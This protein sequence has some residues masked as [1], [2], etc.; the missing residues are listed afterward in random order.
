MPFLLVR[1]SEAIFLYFSMVALCFN[2]WM[3]IFT[4]GFPFCSFDLKL[5]NVSSSSSTG[6]IQW[7]TLNQIDRD[8]LK[9]LRWF[10]VRFRNLP[11]SATIS[12]TVENIVNCHDRPSRLP[13]TLWS[14][15]SDAWPRH[16][17]VRHRL[18]CIAC[19]TRNYDTCRS[20]PVTPSVTIWQQFRVA[21]A[22]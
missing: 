12:G 22:M 4:F 3:E 14:C 1:S 10:Y 21:P 11:L 13:S 20:R 6:S 8:C 16:L 9:V 2:E 7:Q 17:R 18:T 15:S 5:W 19:I